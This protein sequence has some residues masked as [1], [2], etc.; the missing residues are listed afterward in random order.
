MQQADAQGNRQ[1]HKKYMLL[2]IML[3]LAANSYQAAMFLIS[4]LDEH[5]KRLPRFVIVLAPINRQIMDLWFTLIYIRDDFEPRSLLYEQGAYRELREQIDEN[6]AQYGSDPEWQDWISSMELVAAM[7]EAEITLTP[8]QKA[9]PHSTIPSWPHPHQL[10]ERQTASH[11]FL[12]FLHKQFYGKISVESHLKAAGLTLVAGLLLADV[13]PEDHRKTVEERS[14][15]QYKFRH[16]CITVVILLGIISEIELHCNLNNKDQAV[17]V[18]E[19]LADYSH[20]A[21][22]VYEARYKFLL[23]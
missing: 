6:R 12:A 14:I 10:S 8:E 4:D 1:E 20:D 23:R 7:M 11:E 21:K 17:K 18:W 3:R 9:N 22:D 5:P 15:H 19:R 13:G 16:A 2:L